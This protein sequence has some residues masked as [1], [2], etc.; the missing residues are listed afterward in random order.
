MATDKES[1][2]R[3]SVC[4][5]TYNGEKFIGM[6]LNSIIEQLGERDEIIIS[7][8]ESQ[9]QTTQ[10]VRNFTYPGLRFFS[11][12][13][14]KNV[15]SNFENALKRARGQYV[16]LADQDDLWLPDKLNIMLS[17]LAEYDLVVCDCEIIDEEGRCIHP[18]YF[19][20][21]RSG[22]GVIKN[23]KT[24]SYMGSCMA[25]NRRILDRALPFPKNIPMHDW[26][27][28]LIGEVFGTTF[29]C[30]EKLVQYRRHSANVSPFISSQRYGFLQKI[31]FRK[32]LV[33]P[34][35]IT[36]MKDK[37]YY[38]LPAGKEVIT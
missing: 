34:L 30:P 21:R 8:D 13:F 12:H 19:S 3:V 24:N 16:F 35:A 32:N 1:A 25:F 2:C 31:G 14:G 23:I 36:W 17:C 29:F 7:D 6:Q 27:I 9:D 38:D 10:I 22:K 37:L 5:A 26:W 15:I 4:I 18:S 20:L 28:G 11:N 33:L